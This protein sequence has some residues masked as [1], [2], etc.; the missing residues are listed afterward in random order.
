MRK[1]TAGL[2]MS[3]DG[4]VESPDEWR[5]PFDAETGQIMAEGLRSSDAILLGTKTYQQF[6]AYWP[7]AGD[8]VPMA[9]YLNE[10]TKYVVS[11]TLDSVE[12]ANSTL[13]KGD[14]ATE[15]SRIK[16]LPGKNIQIPGSPRLVRALLEEALVDELTLMIQPVALGSG[17]R[18][19]DDLSKRLQLSTLESRKLGNG[20]VLV[21]YA[22]ARD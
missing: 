18:L 12:W 11:R 16:A 6:A 21:T 8:D 14:L 10:T 15:M 9:K 20:A 19:F 4:V 3:L 2:F 17:M 22:P 5:Q 13:L 7:N 1:I